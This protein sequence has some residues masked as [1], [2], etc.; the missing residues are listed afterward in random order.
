MDTLPGWHGPVA[1]GPDFH[2]NLGAIL[3]GEAPAR[4]ALFEFYH[5]GGLYRDIAGQRAGEPDYVRDVRAFAALGYDHANLFPQN[6]FGFPAGEHHRG[7]SISLNEGA[8]ITDRAS[9][10]AYVW[11]RIDALDWSY[12]D[13]AA[14]ALAPGQVLMASGPCGVLENV[15][16]LVGF[17]RLC[18]L[19][20]DDPD[21]VQ[22]VFDGVGSGLLAYYRRVIDHPAVGLLMSND[23]WG[24]KT[25]TML[26]PRQMRRYVFPWHE[27]IVACAHAAGKP[28]VLHSC[29]NLAAVMDDIIDGMGYDGKHSYEDGIT[30]VE[31]AWDRWGSRIAIL[32]GL[33]VDYLCRTPAEAVRA[34]SAA[35]LAHTGGRG[36]AAGTG[37]SVPD[38]VPR[39]AFFAA[40]EP[41]LAGRRRAA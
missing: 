26:S 35:M 16:R 7:Q 18:E 30:R 32:G 12:L 24:F 2:R 36:W 17:E 5:N 11:P 40:I 29:G 19:V 9:C 28:A 8:V 34:R 13:S 41:A 23:D 33:D 1:D 38:W 20:A 27:R 10:E 4:A 6:G 15:I 21:L 39:A 3:R 37:N 25:Q 14:A 31:E 22:A